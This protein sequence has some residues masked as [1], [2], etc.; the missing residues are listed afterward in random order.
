[1]SLKSSSRNWKNSWRN[2]TLNSAIRNSLRFL[3]Y[4]LVWIGVVAVSSL[5]LP[6]RLD[7]VRNNF[8]IGH[9]DG[10]AYAW[11]ARTLVRGDGLNI[12]YIT[13]FFYYY[14][15]EVPR[16]DD[17]WGPLLSFALVPAFARH[18]PEANI[19]RM[20]TVV[21][22]TLLL[23]LSLCMLA[24]ALTRRAWTGLPASLPAW[25]STE[26]MRDGMNLNAD[27]LIAAVL[28]F[29]LAALVASRRFSCLLLL[30]GPL[31]AL[32]W[33]GKGS[34]IILFPFLAGAVAL[35]HGPKALFR[36]SF[37]GSLLLGLLCMFTRLH[38]N[39][40][41]FGT[42]L[43]STQSHVRAF[44]GLSESVW[45]HWDNG[46]YSVFFN[47]EPPG[48][49]NRFDHPH[50]HSRSIRR[51]TEAT[52]RLTL[53]GPDAGVEVWESL[54]EGA[55]SFANALR[56]N[57]VRPLREELAESP[58]GIAPPWRWDRPWFTLGQTAGLSFGFLS[59]ALSTGVWCYRLV[60]KQTFKWETAFHPAAVLFAFVVSQALFVI[61]FWEAMPR[62]TYTATLPA[63]TLPWALLAAMGEGVEGLWR[64]CRPK[65]FPRWFSPLST[66]LFVLAV[67][68]NMGLRS[69]TINREHASTFRNPPPSEPVYPALKRQ[70]ELMAERLPANAVLMCRRPWQTLWYA[71][72]TF[73]AVGIP[74]AE[75]P[76]LLAVA[77]HYGVTHLVLDQR[78]PGLRPF[79]RA[80]P[81]VFEQ[82]IQRPVPTFKLHYE[83]LPEDF[84]PRVRDIQPHWDPRSGLRE[85]ESRLAE[86]SK[87][88]SVN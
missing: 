46:F 31:A 3:P 53:F 41:T 65:P 64:R 15:L 26:L 28:C 5:F 84:L 73:R 59:L 4:P 12:P 39:A 7:R 11:Q 47:V 34:Q 49:R 81:R 33:Y 78:R 60:R 21:I 27:Q 75:P 10:V 35:L 22:S 2:N 68:M 52:L 71:P 80:N 29:F 44:F 74:M 48:L 57:R 58:G 85:E 88:P 19:A 42:P 37:L 1:M 55:E 18:G 72:E 67:Y 9:A 24:Q 50:L 38:H 40:K 43:H 45:T 79:I 20:T 87:N 25:L 51:N 13:N 36:R 62:I 8:D 14:D 82:V 6:T 86:A 63:I 77:K 54:G 61:L 23:P 32:A 83:N 56:V 66:G 16:Q 70:G 69:D 30:C 76:E 17:Q